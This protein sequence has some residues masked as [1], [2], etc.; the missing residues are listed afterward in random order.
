[1]AVSSS[2][3]ERFPHEFET[4]RELADSLPQIVW[5]AL[6]DGTHQYYNKQWSD[7]TGLTL[8][9]STDAAWRERFHPD[10]CERAETAWQQALA[11]GTPYEIEFRLKRSSDDEYR[12]FLG[13]ALPRQDPKGKIVSWFGTCTDIHEQKQTQD[14]LRTARD[15][16]RRENIQKDEFLG[17]VSHELRTP[18]NAV[19]GWTRLMQEHVLEEDERAQAVDSIVRNAEAQARLIEDVLDI[20]R[21]VNQKLSLNPEILN[22]WHIMNDSVDAVLPSAEAKGVALVSAFDSH[23]LLVHGDRNR[24]QQ[25]LVNLLANAVKFTPSGGEI[26]V[27]LGEQN[28][29]SSVTVSDNGQGISPELLPHIFERFRQGD[30]SSTRRHGGLG[31][32]LAIAN[33]LTVLHGGKIEA[34]SAGEGQGSRFTVLL[35][36]LAIG[37]LP[38]ANTGASHLIG[39]EAFPADHLR[40]LHVM[41]VD[42]EP[43]VRELLALTLAKCGA[44]VALAASVHD[45]LDLL[46]D[47]TPDVVVSD[48]AMPGADGYEFIQQ[49][50][51]LVRSHGRD[52]PVIA[53]TACASGQDRDHAMQAGF[54]RY[55]TKPVDPAELV[56][57]IA[58]SHSTTRPGFGSAVA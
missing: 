39:G 57:A 21:I 35:P 32:G 25:V 14:A 27:E 24:L 29:F 36:I 43:S 20:T 28:G 8:E 41:V 12:W 7:Y 48:I 58:E 1:M 49:L 2:A 33:Q 9:N 53:L 31:L 18:L 34:D 10:D 46:P 30:S 17:V 40:G 22:L 45:A 16:L 38:G 5:I 54:N 26:R 13:R 42:D 19:F 55:L 50:R 56:H 4:F 51:G 6:P 23:D 47:L 44:S 37:S 3:G 15:T 11:A 52:V